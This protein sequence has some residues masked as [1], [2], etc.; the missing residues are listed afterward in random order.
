MAL[1]Y[2]TAVQD[3][4]ALRLA[5]STYS[6]LPS[7]YKTAIDNN[8]TSG[9]LA[10]GLA[11]E[12]QTLV[13]RYNDYLEI[14][15]TDVADDALLSWFIW[16]VVF[17]ASHAFQPDREGSSM[18]HRDDAMRH[19]LATHTRQDMDEDGNGLWTIDHNHIR[20][21]AV[22]ACVNMEPPYMP[23]PEMIDRAMR[24][25][26]AKL[27]IYADWRWRK[28]PITIT[29][30]TSGQPTTD[31]SAGQS[32]D[33]I[34]S[35]RLFYD[36]TDGVGTQLVHV[37]AT[38]M[39]YLKSQGLSSA[40]PEYCHIT[41]TGG[42][43]YWEFDRTPDQEYTVRGEA[44]LGIPALTDGADFDTALALIPSDMHDILVDAIVGD[45]MAMSG[46]PAGRQAKA[47]AEEA[48]VHMLGRADDV[49]DY[50]NPQMESE[51][52]R[53]FCSLFAGQEHDLPI[54]GGNL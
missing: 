5:G 41:K 17:R 23:T 38:R 1:T 48:W 37:D 42:T 7:E 34:T 20:S 6:N 27:W 40:R 2:T 33:G 11:F 25:R 44:L 32:L 3:Q 54:V 12:A 49:G 26:I 28:K 16:E 21:T 19:A 46:R 45:V 35:R 43:L 52:R 24:S 10:G 31:L 22:D 50:D 4:I 13:R 30:P 14:S 53:T 39:S 51:V 36:D 9:A 18:R 29:I 8:W 15:G 47:D